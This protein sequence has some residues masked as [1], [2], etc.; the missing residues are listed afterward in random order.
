MDASFFY[1]GTLGVGH[2]VVH[3]RTK[4]KSKDLG[5]DLRDGVDKANG[6]KIGNIFRAILFSQEHNVRGVGLL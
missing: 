1:E 4:T 2:K 5:D 6:P 3:E